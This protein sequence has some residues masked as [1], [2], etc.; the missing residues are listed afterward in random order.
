MPGAPSWRLPFASRSPKRDPVSCSSC[1][2]LKKIAILA[3][4][5]TLRPALRSPTSDGQIKDHAPRECAGE[6]YGVS[7][8]H[9]HPPLPAAHHPAARCPDCSACNCCNPRHRTFGRCMIGSGC[10]DGI[11]RRI[12]LRWSSDQCKGIGSL[13]FSWFFLV[14]VLRNLDW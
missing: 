13:F 9:C 7:P 11:R 12:C 5:L 4:P 2:F 6:H 8:K 1:C 3:Q 14:C 10:C